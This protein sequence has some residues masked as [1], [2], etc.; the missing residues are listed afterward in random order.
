M[1]YKCLKMSISFTHRRSLLQMVSILA[2]CQQDIWHT[3]S[4]L[5]YSLRT[6]PVVAHVFDTQLGSCIQKV[7]GE[8][9]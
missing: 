1:H 5:N 8:K 2:T 7:S 9:Q 4:C 3:L 6:W